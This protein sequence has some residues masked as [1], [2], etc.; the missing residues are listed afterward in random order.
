MKLKTLCCL[1]LAFTLVITSCVDPKVAIIKFS[2]ELAPLEIR[3]HQLNILWN[4]YIVR[5]RVSREEAPLLVY[6]IEHWRNQLEVLNTELNQIQAPPQLA[7]VKQL[8]LEVYAKRL[9]YCTLSIRYYSVRDEQAFTE[10]YRLIA[11]ANQ[12]HAKAIEEWINVLEKYGISLEEIIIEEL[13]K[14]ST[15]LTI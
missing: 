6:R 3:H 7:H 4:I 14:N 1:L 10:A 12:L 2:Q 8:F 9:A 5:E 13:S 15:L 11:E